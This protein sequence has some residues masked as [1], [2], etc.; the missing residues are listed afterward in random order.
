MLF[1]PIWVKYSQAAPS[2]TASAMG[3]VPDR[4]RGCLGKERSG[5]EN[6]SYREGM[7]D[8]SGVTNSIR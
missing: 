6:V 2:P 8:T 7:T 3:G 1:M 4:G 5:E